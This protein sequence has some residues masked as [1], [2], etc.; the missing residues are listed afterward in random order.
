MPPPIVDPLWNR[1]DQWLAEAHDEPRFT[2]IG[3][4]TSVASLSPSHAHLA[5]ERVRDVLA[6]LSTFDG[7]RGLDLR[8]LAAADLGDWGVADLDVFAALHSIEALA[9]ELA[10]GPVRAFLGGDNAITRPL[11]RGLAHEDLSAIGVL[12]LDA[13]HDVR[14]LDRGPTNGNPI[15][16]LIRDGLPGSH[17]VQVGILAFANSRDYRDECEARGIEVRSR[18]DVEARG[19]ETVMSETLATLGE[20]C[21]RI[22]VD[23]DMDVLDRAFAPAC[24]GARPGGLAPRELFAAVRLAGRHPK[25]IGADFVEVDP[26]RDVAD[27]TL[28]NTATALLSFAAGVLERER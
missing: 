10:P 12:T 25:V 15:S 6:R 8:D 22:F 17:V 11:V 9:R 19:I 20:R 2:L 5:P 23:V 14:S 26:E 28:F 27:L 18:S 21:E 7:E 13:H 16:G 4:P 3:V 1:A 24:P